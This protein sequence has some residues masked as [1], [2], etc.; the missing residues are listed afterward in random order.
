MIR[1]SRQTVSVSVGFLLTP[2][3]DLG[4]ERVT[5]FLERT[6]AE[7][8]HFPE[9]PQPENAIF[10]AREEPFALQVQVTTGTVQAPD[11]LEVTQFVI[12]SSA[13]PT[14]PAAPVGDFHDVAHEIT[15]VARDVWPELQQVLA[16]NAGLKALFASAA[17]H[18]FQYLWE[19]RLAQAPDS[20]SQLA[21]P[22]AGGG[23]RV[24]LAPGAEAT[25]QFQ[26]EIR[27]E[28]YLADSRFLL[29]EMDLASAGAGPLNLLNPTAL[30]QTAERF[31]SDRVE[32]FLL[33]G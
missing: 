26:A 19:Q 8:V 12:F 32:P 9:A 16:W 22:I 15:D 31:F 3:L 30:V 2:S 18:S 24:I 10:L 29:A 13:T 27:A 11:P 4:T 23:I 5:Q 21:R 1:D 28:S 17:E 33:G 20:F 6:A 7:G 25:E 14:A